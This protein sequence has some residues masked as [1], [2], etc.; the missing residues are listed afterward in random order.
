MFAAVEKLYRDGVAYPPQW[1]PLVGQLMSYRRPSH[2][3]LFVQL[4][5]LEWLENIDNQLEPLATLW[6]PEFVGILHSEFIVRGVEGTGQAPRRRW[7]MQKW[8]CRPLTPQAA[9]DYLRPTGDWGR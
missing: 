7:L 5:P 2:G 8:R 9:R 4:W 3:T 6:Q 1:P